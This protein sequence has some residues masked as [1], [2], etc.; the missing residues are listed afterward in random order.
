M[1]LAEFLGWDKFDWEAT[2]G[3][4]G[5][6]FVFFPLLVNGLIVFIVAQVIGERTQNQAYARGEDSG[7]SG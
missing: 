4:V 3:L 5:V 1:L 2:A 6:F 7:S